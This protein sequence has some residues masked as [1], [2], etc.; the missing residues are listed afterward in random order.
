MP[1]KCHAG[2][3]PCWRAA[4]TPDALRHFA[5][6]GSGRATWRGGPSWHRVGGPGRT[7][8]ALR[9]GA[10]PG[11]AWFCPTRRR[12]GRHPAG[13]RQCTQQRCAGRGR[14]CAA[15]PAA[16]ATAR[17]LGAAPC[18]AAGRRPAVSPAA[19]AAAAVQL[20]HFSWAAIPHLMVRPPRG[21][22]TAASPAAADPTRCACCA[23]AAAALACD[24]GLHQRPL[25]S[26]SCAG[27]S[28]G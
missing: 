3:T 2:K 11:A 27:G 13:L 28:I 26:L 24:A 14:C 15:G 18:T 1:A 7:A 9:A 5:A 23:A 8:S 6:A 22:P 19:A 20:Q 4:A 16:G 25:Q 17:P 12:P 21:W 10:G